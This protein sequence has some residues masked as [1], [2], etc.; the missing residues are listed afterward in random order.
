[1]STLNT[2]EQNASFWTHYHAAKANLAASDRLPDPADL[3]WA[4]EVVAGQSIA[5]EPVLFGVLSIALKAIHGRALGF[6]ELARMERASRALWAEL[7]AAVPPYK[8][9]WQHALGETG[10]GL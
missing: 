8:T 10:S 4:R 3:A 1:M 2:P 6:T 7:A 9:R 5:S